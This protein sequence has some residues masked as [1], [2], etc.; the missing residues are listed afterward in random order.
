MQLVTTIAKSEIAGA[1]SKDSLVETGSLIDSKG[2]TVAAF[3]RNGDGSF[4]F[5]LPADT[6]IRAGAEQIA[7]SDGNAG[8]GMVLLASV[9]VNLNDN[10]AADQPLFTCPVSRKAIILDLVF[11]DASDDVGV[12]EVA[13]GWGIGGDGVATLISFAASGLFH[14][15]S[16]RAGYPDIGA[17]VGFMKNS[18][19]V[20]TAG[21]VLNLSV[22]TAEG[23]ARTVIVDV[24]GYLTNAA[25][26]PQANISVP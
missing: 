19:R 6:V 16:F 13:V 1:D 3:T 24:W 22:Q 21:Q 10:T 8:T 7:P 23:A 2:N 5:D 18:C 12:A 4:A 15:D 20:G 25:G 17:S 26:V 11:H 9:L 14:Q